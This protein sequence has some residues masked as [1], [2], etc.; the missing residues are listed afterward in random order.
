MTLEEKKQALLAKQQDI[1]SLQKELASLDADE[2][3]VQQFQQLLDSGIEIKQ[4][5]I[6]VS[7]STGEALKATIVDNSGKSYSYSTQTATT[8]HM[9]A[10][11]AA[12]SHASNDVNARIEALYNQ[13]YL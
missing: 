1:N 3:Q 2:Q 8:M 10:I 9:S 5:N 12:L 6:V 13:M 11:N 7:P 4:L